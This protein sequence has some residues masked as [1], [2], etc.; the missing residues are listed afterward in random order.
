MTTD[1]TRFEQFVEFSAVLTGFSR[2]D[3]IGTGVASDYCQTLKSA[4]GEAVLDRMLDRFVQLKDQHSGLDDLEAAVQ[5]EFW[6]DATFGPVS[7]NI[8]LMWYSGQWNQLPPDWHKANGSDPG[9]TTHIVSAAAYQEGL[10][11]R[12]AGTHPQ[13]AKQ[14]GYGTWSFPP[15]QIAVDTGKRTK[16]AQA[17]RGK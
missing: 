16:A 10:V 9:D 11:W 5:K 12:A 13:G 14:P 7:Q 3:L 6:N 2:L 17:G 4:A 15:V 8:V 1:H